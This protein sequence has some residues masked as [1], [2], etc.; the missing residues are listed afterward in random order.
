[1]NLDKVPEETDS[2]NDDA[3]SV[4]SFRSMSY[5]ITPLKEVLSMQYSD[6]EEQTSGKKAVDKNEESIQKKS[7]KKKSIP[8]VNSPLPPPLQ[9]R[10]PPL[11]AQTRPPQPPPPPGE[12][13]TMSVPVPFQKPR[14]SSKDLK[15][16]KK[17][18]RRAE[19]ILKMGKILTS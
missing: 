2:D 13:K 9:E 17:K 6:S 19:E 4:A 18:L 8:K 15:L 11:P 10:A 16:S 3:G 5:P 12:P 7:G 1:M 14:F